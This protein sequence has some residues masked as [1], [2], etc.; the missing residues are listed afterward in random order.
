MSAKKRRQSKV[1]TKP[2][3]TDGKPVPK[4]LLAEFND[5]HREMTATSEMVEQAAA[6][7]KGAI[8]I[9]ADARAVYLHFEKKI[10]TKCGLKEGDLVHP[11]GRVQLLVV[12]P[13]D[14]AQ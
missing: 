4:A 5:A 2:K 12:P 14:G 3:Y 10:Q 13:A 1:S 11:D 8:A 6:V 7:H 9:A